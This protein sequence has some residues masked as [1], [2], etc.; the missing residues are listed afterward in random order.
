MKIIKTFIFILI[1]ACLLSCEKENR[2]SIHGLWLVEK[3]EVGEN[4]MTP[5]ARWTK[6]NADR[7]Q[8]SG[9]G[10]LQHSNGN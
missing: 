1:A 5:V 6:F 7:T 8:T 10:W 2:N 4:S 3:V 9:N